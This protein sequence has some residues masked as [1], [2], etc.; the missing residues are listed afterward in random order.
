MRLVLRNVILRVYK[1][2]ST[3]FSH[4]CH[5][6][7]LNT[8][9]SQGLLEMAMGTVGRV[10]I[11]KTGEGVRNFQLPRASS[12]V[13]LQSLPL[14]DLFLYPSELIR[15]IAHILNIKKL[16][17]RKVIIRHLNVSEDTRIYYNSCYQ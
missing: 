11:P 12:W 10:Y 5:L 14:T 7:G 8:S 13:N 1:E 17:Q 2:V 16:K 15:D 4:I 6:H 3:G 9:L